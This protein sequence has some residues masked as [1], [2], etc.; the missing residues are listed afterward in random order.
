MKIH[1]K[2]NGPSWRGYFEVGYELTSG[3]PDLKEGYYFGR[4]HDSEL[5]GVKKGWPTFGK[6]VWP[7]NIPNF[8]EKFPIY[9][10]KLETI[11]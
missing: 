3:I 11:A 9:W 1:M 7:E 5:E 2:N 8:K 6:N 4:E 10:D